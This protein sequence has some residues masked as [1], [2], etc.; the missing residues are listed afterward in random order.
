MKVIAVQKGGTW[1]NNWQLYPLPLSELQKDL[2]LK[3]NEGYN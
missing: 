2:N 1:E 3:Q